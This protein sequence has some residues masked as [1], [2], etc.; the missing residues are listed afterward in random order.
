MAAEDL[1]TQGNNMKGANVNHRMK[2]QIIIIVII[3]A[4]ASITACKPT[5]QVQKAEITKELT[6]SELREYNYALTEATKQKLFGNFQ[7]AAALY[8]T[9]IEVNPQSDAAHF[10]LA[11]MFMMARDLEGAIKLNRRAIEL[12]P[13]NY[14]YRIQMGQ[15]YMLSENLDSA[16][17]TYEA[18][19]ERW[20]EKIEIR[21]E[22]ARLNSE[23]GKH[24]RAIKILDE[25]EKENGISE[26]V[27]MLKEQIYLRDGKPEM[28]EKELLALIE[29]FPEEIRF[30]GI[31]DIS[32]YL[33][34]EAFR[35]N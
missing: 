20:P 32:Q 8:Q 33:Y 2:T 5:K 15:L 25:I 35:K 34:T 29:L 4:I 17:V 16:I 14:W 18:I 22:L 7:Q 31:L 28:A 21:Y 10:Q 23:I 11:G 9:C 12:N 30:L 13:D 24:S 6:E 26:P 3:V 19:S 27:T 1:V